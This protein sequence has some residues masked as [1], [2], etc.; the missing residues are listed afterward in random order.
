MVVAE[1]EALRRLDR[2]GILLLDTD[3][4][5]TG[6][7]RLTD[8]IAVDDAPAGELAATAHRLFD[9]SVPERV[10]R[11]GAWALGP[12]ARLTLQGRTG[13]GARKRLQREG[14]R[15]V[16]GLAHGQ[17]LLA[18]LS[19]VPEMHDAASAFVP[20]AQAAGLKAVAAGTCTTDVS[21]RE[22]DAVT[23]GGD[24]LLHS[25]RALQRDGDG[26]PSR[27]SPGP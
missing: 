13:E 21:V 18:V 7:Y 1:P 20:A 15:V 10:Q 6:S 9:G 2:I 25:V 27:E 26:V 24:R 3:A 22:A 14:A 5:A 16:L 4:L 23:E 8:L 11:D 12:V 17:R 19:V